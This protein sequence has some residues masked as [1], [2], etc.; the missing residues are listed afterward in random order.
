VKPKWKPGRRKKNPFNPN[1][2]YISEAVEAFL[3]G[4][5]KIARVTMEDVRNSEINTI[6]EWDR[7]GE[8]DWHV[9]APQKDF[10]PSFVEMGD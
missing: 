9:G 3:K 7:E 10:K 8:S 4:G 6:S 2:Q 5:G 1:S